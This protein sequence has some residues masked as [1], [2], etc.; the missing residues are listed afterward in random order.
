ML[1]HGP[2]LEP[3][4]TEVHTQAGGA[5][6]YRK[7]LRDFRWR[8]L[9][10]LLEE[11]FDQWTKH[12]APRL[13]AALSFYTLLSLAPLLLFLVAI[14][15]LA[16]GPN[17]AA[18]G[19]IA[20]IRVLGGAEAARAAQ[21]LLLQP[22][23]ATHGII[24]TIVS[25]LTLLFG[26]SGVLV[27]LRDA[28]NT[29]W[30]V[31]LP[32]LTGFKRIAAFAQERLFSFALVL[33]VGFLLVVSLAISAWLAAL[34]AYSASILPAHE[35]I[36][37]VVNFLLSFFIVALLFSAIYKFLPYT[38]IEWYE[39]ILG[40]SVT[41]VLFTVGKFVLGFY[42]G[43]ASFASAYGAA[44]SIVALI[45]WVYYSAQ[46]FFLGAEFTKVF[47]NHYGPPRHRRDLHIVTPSEDCNQPRNAKPELAR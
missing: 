27:E 4:G 23:S 22:P 8:D 39:V 45:A 36:L 6:A 13:G 37:N 32:Q 1:D 29:I 30:D 25:L 47:A 2:I 24:A 15:S 28:L 14:F 35:L 31:P 12:N 33:A 9:R 19:V 38:R 21:A 16:V 10:A 43:R 46:I 34:G 26:A 11:S 20:Q 7:P 18:N 41:S 5:R 44:A 40:G 17:A 42:L 3:G